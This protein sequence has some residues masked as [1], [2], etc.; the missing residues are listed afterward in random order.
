MKD[1]AGK[2]AVITG[3]AGGIGNATGGLLAARGMKV[4]LADIEQAALESAV[5]EFIAQPWCP[6]RSW[7]SMRQRSDPMSHMQKA[8]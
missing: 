1:L 4:V 7:E 5:D 8:T 2:V 3:G 6:P